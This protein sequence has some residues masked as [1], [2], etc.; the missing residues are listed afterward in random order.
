MSEPRGKGAVLKRRVLGVG[1]IVLVLGLIALSVA[2]QQH[3]FRDVVTIKLET[4]KVGNQLAVKSDVKARG[5]FVGH[6]SKITPTPNGA[7]LDLQIN[8]AHAAQIPKDSS[9]RIMP[10][11][12]FGERYVQLTFESLSGPRMAEGDVIAQDRSSAAIELGQSFEKLLPV[13]RAVQPHKLNSTLTAMANALDG[14]GKELGQT[15]SELGKYFGELNPHLPELQQNLRELAKFSDNLESV[16]PELIETLDNFRTSSKTLVDK[17]ENLA[18][19]FATV[20]IASQDLEEFIRANKDNI[21]TVN[22]VSKK[23]LQ[24]LAKYS[25]SVPCVTS[26]MAAAVPK[27]DAALGKGTSNPGLRAKVVI[28][29][30]QEKY[31][32]GQDEPELHPGIGGVDDQGKDWG[33]YRGPW[34]VDPLHPDIPSVLPVPYKFIRFTDGSN[35]ADKPDPR[36]EWDS[37]GLP[38]DA[39][40]VFGNRVPAAW[41]KSCAPGTRPENLGGTTG[42]GGSSVPASSPAD[43]PEENALLAQLLSVQIGMDVDQ[44]PS[45]GSML[46]GPLYRGAEV[47]IR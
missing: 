14:R 17:R 45:W 10:K 4:D 5:V 21:I 39:V 3:A 11:T 6:V 34:C 28:G 46:V 2:G 18:A 40:N 47:E 36:S 24:L 33:Q 15:L 31:T 43:T 23:T 41:L 16:A 8:P 25:P 29:P 12:L 26:Q 30:T 19:T 44:M 27:I 9:A 1:F 22:K 20:N 35:P 7:V 13:L 38:C 42:G 32:P 37:K